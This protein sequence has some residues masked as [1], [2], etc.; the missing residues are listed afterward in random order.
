M[1]IISNNPFRIIGVPS[2]AS[3]RD[4]AANQSRLKAY[5]AASKAVS[6]PL[7]CVGG[8]GE[9]NR[10]TAIVQQAIANINLPQDKVAHALFWFIK[11]EDP[12]GSMAWEYL[13][14]GDEDKAIEFFAKR[15]SF[16][17]L[18][19]RGVLAFIAGDS[20]T[21]ITCMG[22]MIQNG[23]MRA[24]FV[25]AV[26]DD[27]FQIS[28]DELAELFFSKVFEEIDAFDVFQKVGDSIDSW[29]KDH[30]RKYSIQKSFSF[31]EES[32]AKAKSIKG[33][34]PDEWWRAGKVLI[35]ETHNIRLQLFS[36][37][38]ESD[39]SFQRLADKL[40]LQILQCGINY[41]N[42]ADEDEA[43]EVNKAYEIQ[44]YALSIAIGKL[45]V[46]R[47]KQNVD[48]LEKKRKGLP[49]KEVK[50]YDEL[51]KIAL[52]DYR[53]QA[54][55]I[56]NAI[57]L[58]E[59]CVHYLMSIKAEVGQTNEYYLQIS[60]L[61]VNA[62]LHNVI[63]E[64][65]SFMNGVSN[66]Q[67]TAGRIEEIK[68]V[69][70]Q[71]WK[72]TL[73][74]DI[75][76]KEVDFANGRYKQNREALEGQVK[77]LIDIDRKVIVLDSYR[78]ARYDDYFTKVRISLPDS[79]LS[80]LGLPSTR[81]NSDASPYRLNICT[82]KVILD[83]CENIKDFEYYFLL[84]PKGKGRYSRQVKKRMEECELNSC[85]T[86]QDCKNFQEKYPNTKLPIL[87]K[88]EE[89]YF[90]SCKTISEFENYR[91][92]YPTGKYVQRA[93]N[94]IDDLTFEKCKNATDYQNYLSKF[95]HGNHRKEAQDEACWILA[96]NSGKRSSYKNYLA[97]FPNGKHKQEAEELAKA[98]YIATMVYG[99][100]DHTQVVALRKFR[101]TVLRNSAIG[102]VFI[103]YYY[104]HSPSWVEKLQDKP[105]VNRVIRLLLDNFIK[106][107][108]NT[109]NHEK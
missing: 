85:R 76:D 20:I 11:P 28:E 60:T 95:P 24:E 107:Y 83:E 50:C 54:E 92:K 77:N 33:K 91:K 100:Y 1:N 55:T 27:T 101:D 45:A 15:D 82:E 43:T 21:G 14:K 72:A 70:E 29:I 19:N 105:F 49:P 53:N 96:K 12:V 75:L 4:I 56:A 9:L 46:D 106:I 73:F 13:S 41:Y 38:G 31:I 65:N 2:N 79:V 103:K 94:K 44:N 26:A 61:V 16:A 69:F 40:A 52:V 84:F 34:N 59:K 87:E 32:I 30:T 102:N 17:A 7:D 10:D 37:V 39:S 109:N 108:T 8:Q 22:K 68:N 66:S 78:I 90:Q 80:H 67:L 88:W 98:C 5:L 86:I 71:A 35:D 18:V 47:C 6:F 64:F 99:D 42:N 74:M 36:I 3:A 97:Q 57:K 93:V 48:I 62:A 104:M 81:K 63:E 51:I 25:K 23:T 58:I 89:C